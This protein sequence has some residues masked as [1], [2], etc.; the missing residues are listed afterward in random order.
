MQIRSSFKYFGPFQYIRCLICAI[1]IPWSN[2]AFPAGELTESA[3]PENEIVVLLHGLGRSNTAM[4]R[5]AGRLE[6][7]GYDVYQVGYSSIKTTPDE[8]IETIT[9]QINACCISTP[10]TVHFVGHSLGGLLIRAYLSSH[11]PP[12]LG[13]TV[14]LGTPNNGSSV[15]DQVADHALVEYLLPV[16]IELGTDPDSFPNRL[17]PPDYPVGIIAGVVDSELREYFLPEP[18]DGIVPVESTR[19]EGMTDFIEI[20]SGHSMM[21]YD[22]DVA[23]QTSYFLK[24]QRFLHDQSDPEE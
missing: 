17:P 11:R 6:D 9:E 21:R 24:H 18:N 22:A 8:M 23:K 3:L 2:P 16:A 19:L 13:N 7:D 1:L 5:L 4:W 15:A 14:L 10:R 20:P 12:E